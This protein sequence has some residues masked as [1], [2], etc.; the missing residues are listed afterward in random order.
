MKQNELKIYTPVKIEVRELCST[1][2]T[3]RCANMA[4]SSNKKKINIKIKGHCQLCK[5][6]MQWSTWQY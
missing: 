5:S 1:S 4:K 2:F 6:K 3:E